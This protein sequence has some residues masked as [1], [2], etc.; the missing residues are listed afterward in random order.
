MDS[1]SLDTE[2]AEADVNWRRPPGIFVLAEVGGE[3]GRRIREIQLRHDPRLAAALPPHVTL[4]G[5]SG[6]GPIAAATGM[7]ELRRALEPIAASTPPLTLALEPP[8]RFLQTDIVVLPLDPNGPIR[9]L[10]ER[11]GSS[12][13]SFGP[14]RFTFTPHVTLTFFRTLTREAIRELMAIRIDEPVVIDH[15]RCSLTDE[16]LPPRNL[17]ELALRG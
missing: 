7:E 15:L 2:A 11:I 10:H 17:L 6:L 1:E 13:L 14:V 3:A 5:S 4:A 9:E 8:H 16:P 12:G